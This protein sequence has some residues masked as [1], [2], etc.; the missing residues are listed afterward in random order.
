MKKYLFLPLFLLAFT[1]SV[2]LAEFRNGMSAYQRGDYTRAFAIWL[3]LAEKGDAKSQNNLGILYRRGMGVLKNEKKAFTWYERAATQ[4]FAKGQYNLALLYKRGS[5]VE[6]NEK[7]AFKWLEQ[8]AMNGYP[9]ALL[10]LGTRFEKGSG[11]KKDPVKALM[12][13]SLAVKKAR[14]KTLRQ[15]ARARG[16][17]LGKLS[18]QQISEA[19]RMQSL[20]KIGS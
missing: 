4:G 1:S 13:L 5:G 7:M 8:A 2:A 19:R 17:L 11:V 20:V 12:W 18:E 9:R 10:D 3:P 6:R 15:A 16:R 14:G